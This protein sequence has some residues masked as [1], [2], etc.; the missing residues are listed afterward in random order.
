[1]RKNN[2]KK[3]TVIATVQALI[4]AAMIVLV[5]KVVPVC[6]GMLEL[7]SGKEVHMKCYYTGVVLVCLGVLM[8][9]NALLYLVTKQG[10]ACGVM[11]IALATVVFVIFSNSMGIGICANI[12]MP[13]NLTAPFAKMCALI[14]MVCGVLALITGLKGSG[15]QGAAR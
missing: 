4:A 7:T 6:S 10:V 11:T 1:M 14:E 12:D 2:E 15:K 9:V 8:I 3:G 5:T 13:C